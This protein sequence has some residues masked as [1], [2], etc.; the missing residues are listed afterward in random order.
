M[1]GM[2]IN[3]IN[4]FG[5][6]GIIVYIRIKLKLISPLPLPGYLH[7]IHLRN[8]KSDFISFREIFF[9]KE[10]KLDLPATIKPTVIVDAGANIG[11]TSVYFANLY[12][13]AK[14]ICIEPDSENFKCVVKNVSN[15]KNII[16]LNKALWQASEML[17]LSNKGFGDRGFMIED[18]E[19]KTIEGISVH[20]LMQEHNLHHIDIL[21]IDIEGSEKE[22]FG[23]GYDSWLPKTKCL[24]IELHDRMKPGCS[25]SVF[26]A[27]GKYNF[28]MSIK[29]E[30]LV[31]INAN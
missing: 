25:A 16:P 26:S 1:L 3:C 12:P 23:E 29:G 19:N 15:Y 14:I 17:S 31:F 10:Y 21:K 30:N 11:L 24:V 4:H 28:S 22:V 27:L 18:G 6:A 20:A 7:P 13:D 9:K 5:L 8:S 2:L